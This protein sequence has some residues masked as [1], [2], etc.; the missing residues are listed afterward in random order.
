LTCLKCAERLQDRVIGIPVQQATRLL[1]RHQMDGLRLP[2]YVLGMADRRKPGMPSSMPAHPAA[3][4]V[5]LRMPGPGRALA[6]IV[7]METLMTWLERL[8]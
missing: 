4:V 2:P 1:R 6:V 8:P 7:V 3:V 5:R